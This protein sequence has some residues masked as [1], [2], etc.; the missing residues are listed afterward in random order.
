MGG[1]PPE[2]QATPKT[3]KGRSHEE[4]D[5]EYGEHNERDPCHSF[6]YYSFHF[7]VVMVDLAKHNYDCGI[8]VNMQEIVVLMNKNKDFMELDCQDDYSSRG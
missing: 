6:H 7:C 3:K 1:G 5:E 2:T 8:R 4:H